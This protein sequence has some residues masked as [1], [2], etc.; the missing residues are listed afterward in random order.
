MSDMV[1]GGAALP[2]CHDPLAVAVGNGSLL[3]VAY[4]LIG[5]RGLALGTGLV[6]VDSSG[7]WSRS[8]RSRC[9]PRSCL[10]I[11]AGRIPPIRHGKRTSGPAGVHSGTS[12]LVHMI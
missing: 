6:T 12:I 11:R 9:W 7:S 10:A 8:W 3:G 5:R 2:G 1:G 4:L